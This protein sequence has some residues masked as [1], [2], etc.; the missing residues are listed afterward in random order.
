MYVW[1]CVYD[2]CRKLY[3]LST[4]VRQTDK[5]F[6]D[7]G[8]K[9]KTGSKEEEEAKARTE[10]MEQLRGRR[11]DRPLGV[12]ASQKQRPEHSL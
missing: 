10:E 2:C 7:G 1:L 9:I 5:T 6:E 8:E 4:R 11:R 12:A 3:I